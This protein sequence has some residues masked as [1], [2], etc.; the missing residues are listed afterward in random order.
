MS[1]KTRSHIHISS[2]SFVDPTRGA[3]LG[4]VL[5]PRERAK[6]T[7]RDGLCPMVIPHF[8][9]LSSS[10]VMDVYEITCPETLPPHSEGNRSLHISYGFY[11]R[12][13]NNSR[14]VPG[15]RLTQAETM[16]SFLG[17]PGTRK[18]IRLVSFCCLK[19]S[20]V[21]LKSCGQSWSASRERNEVNT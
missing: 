1:C 11:P 3:C 12:F 16:N 8:V 21:K 5:V 2:L 17:F 13:P 9:F 4:E 10:L 14:W 20:N 15:C 19:W 7:A 18:N 6:L